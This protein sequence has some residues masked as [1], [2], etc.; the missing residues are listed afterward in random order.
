[1]G[2]DMSAVVVK[3]AEIADRMIAGDELTDAELAQYVEYHFEYWRKHHHLH[4]WMQRLYAERTGDEN[5][6]NFNCVYVD[7]TESDLC[8]LRDDIFDGKLQPTQGFFFG[9]HTEYAREDI[10]KDLA[11]IMKALYE[12]RSGNRVLYHSWW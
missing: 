7:L 12:V 6:D 10:H 4:G 5:P 1:M 3:N 2:L 9:S 8:R 11:F